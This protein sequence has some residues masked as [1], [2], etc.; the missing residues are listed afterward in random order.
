MFLLCFNFIL[1]RKS[2]LI[3]YI[4]LTIWIFFNIIYN[5]RWELSIILK[6]FL[7]INA[8][9]G[10]IRFIY[11]FNF[12]ISFL[13]TLFLSLIN[14]LI[15]LLCQQLLMDD[16]WYNLFG[17]FRKTISFQTLFS[18]YIKMRFWVSLSKLVWSIYTSIEHVWL[19]YFE[20]NWLSCFNLFC[21]LDS[22]GLP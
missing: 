7:K 3:E 14:N 21:Y 2:N 11:Q 22:I 13:L 4:K 6:W 5:Y 12:L 17:G 9:R 19:L 10:L 16:I 8:Q 1:Y 15:L 18:N 20:L